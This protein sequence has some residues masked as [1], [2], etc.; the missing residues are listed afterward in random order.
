MPHRIVKSSFG[1]IR[2]DMSFARYGTVQITSP[3]A[4]SPLNKIRLAR[5]EV[6]HW[7]R[8]YSMFKCTVLTPT[9]TRTVRAKHNREIS[10]QTASDTSVLRIGRYYEDKS[11]RFETRLTFDLLWKKSFGS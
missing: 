8:L 5:R 7:A 4:R 2:A 3:P 6:R 11:Y 9:G 10:R 1:N